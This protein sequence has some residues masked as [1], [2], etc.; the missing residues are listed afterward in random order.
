MAKKINKHKAS[1]TTRQDTSDTKSNLNYLCV[2]PNLFMETKLDHHGNENPVMSNKQEKRSSETKNIKHM[3]KAIHK[4]YIQPL[5]LQLLT[6]DKTQ[7]SLSN[8][9][10]I[11]REKGDNTRQKSISTHN[12]KQK[13]KKKRGQHDEEHRSNTHSNKQHK[14]VTSNETHEKHAHFKQSGSKGDPPG[15]PRQ[16]KE[17]KT[18]RQN[19]LHI[20]Y[21]DRLTNAVIQT[22]CEH[23]DQPLRDTPTTTPAVNC[24]RAEKKLRNE[25]GQSQ[26]GQIIKHTFTPQRRKQRHRNNKHEPKPSPTTNTTRPHIQA[27]TNHYNTWEKQTHGRSKTSSLQSSKIVGHILLAQFDQ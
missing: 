8:D 9:H 20:T 16:Q 24:K 27:H 14:I 2:K 3:K 19:G 26:C 6:T 23:H 4:V 22:E 1:R 18:F 13:F 12:A 17:R 15:Q 11:A 5:Y 25:R 21:E 7:H 10:T